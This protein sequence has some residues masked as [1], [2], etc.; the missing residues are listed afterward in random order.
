MF[1]GTAV[2]TEVKELNTLVKLA[3]LKLEEEKVLLEDNLTLPQP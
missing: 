2:P 1:K 3:E